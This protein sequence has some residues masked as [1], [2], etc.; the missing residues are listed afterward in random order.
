[1]HSYIDIGKST[2]TITGEDGA[3][4]KQY[5]CYICLYL[6][7]EFNKHRVQLKCRTFFLQVLSKSSFGEASIYEALRTHEEGA[8]LLE[9]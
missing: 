6:F 9:K 7:N 2:K 3:D 8:K 4:C 1:M 5:Y